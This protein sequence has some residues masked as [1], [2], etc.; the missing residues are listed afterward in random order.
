MSGDVE[1]SG[2]KHLKEQQRLGIML[3]ENFVLISTDT[4]ARKL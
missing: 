2:E 3:A 1:N 4:D